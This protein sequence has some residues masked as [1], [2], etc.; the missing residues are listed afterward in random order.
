MIKL[1]RVNTG[2]CGGCDQEIGVAVA[3]AHDL[4]W[5]ASPHEADALLLTGP[6][7]LGSRAAFVRFLRDVGPQ[8]LLAI[9]RCAIDGH[10]FGRGGVQELSN[11][12][13]QLKLDG[14]PPEPAEIAAAIRAALRQPAVEP[15]EH[16]ETA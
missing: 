3:E 8:P 9:G 2:S 14:C 5:S 10:P 16:E 13:V 7:T 11:I 4:T 1:Y 15:D 6:I 12:T